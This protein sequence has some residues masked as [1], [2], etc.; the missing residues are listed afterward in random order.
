MPQSLSR[1]VIP[2][3]SICS[4]R[5]H[6]NSADANILVTRAC[7]SVVLWPRS[8]QHSLSR[9]AWG[10]SRW[11]ARGYSGWVNGVTPKQM[12][13]RMSRPP[14]L[15]S[16]L[17]HLS[18]SS[19][20]DSPISTITVTHPVAHA[21]APAYRSCRNLIAAFRVR[22]AILAKGTGRCASLAASGGGGL[23][24]YQRDAH[25]QSTPCARLTSGDARPATHC[26]SWGL[27]FRHGFCG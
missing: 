9:G 3:I 25:R 8:S 13:L 10:R 11:Q 27:L 7:P 20:G 21:Q 2:I 19:F 24:C 23:R 1:Q 18:P 4:K 22:A 5:A 16:S 17:E 12:V 14:V 6:K 26:R 15:L